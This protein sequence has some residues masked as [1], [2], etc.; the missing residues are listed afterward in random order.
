MIEKVGMSL[1]IHDTRMVGVASFLRRHDH[2]LCLPLSTGRLCHG[3]MDGFGESGR[4][5]QIITPLPFINPRCLREASRK[6]RSILPVDGLDTSVQRHHVLLQL[7]TV[8]HAISPIQPCLPAIVHKHGWVEI[9]PTVLGVCGHVIRHQRMSQSVLERTVRG[10]TYGYTDGRSGLKPV[11]RRNIPIEL[12]IPPDTLRR[13]GIARRPTESART[14]HRTVVGP[15][16]HIR[17]RI[18]AI[19]PHQ[20]GIPGCVLFVTPYI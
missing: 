9:I 8:T 11:L 1:K 16:H 20:V 15:I 13:T 10:I 12:T 7:G 3:I 14:E 18:Q 4:I 19:L 6:G 17:S 2:T 5:N